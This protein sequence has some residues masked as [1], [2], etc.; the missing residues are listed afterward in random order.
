MKESFRDKK[1]CIF[2]LFGIILIFLGSY[3]MFKMGF[4]LVGIFGAFVIIVGALFILM[5]KNVD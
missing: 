3:Y 5:D 1:T 4:S 2:E